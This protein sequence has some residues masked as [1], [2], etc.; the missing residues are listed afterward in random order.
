MALVTNRIAILGPFDDV[1]L[2]SAQLADDRLHACA[3]H[4]DA[5]ADRID[6]A[7]ARVHRDL[8]AIAGLAH[9]PAN[10][11]RAVV[12][13]RHFLLE[14]LDEE[15][16]IGA[17][18]DDLGPLGAAVH[19][20]DD[21]AHAIAGRVVLG[22]RLFLA[23]ELRFDPAELDDDVAVLE[24]LHHAADHFADALAVLGVDVLAL[25]LP[26]LLKDHLLGRLGGDAAQIFGRARE[27]DLHV[28]FRFFAV[29][30]LRFAERDL[31]R[32]VGDFG[33]DLLDRVQ[34]ELAGLR[35]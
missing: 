10:H 3:L 15:R 4:A 28:D 22:A 25:S 35:D 29:E 2:F 5:R 31:R 9:G 11:H 17:R 12:D 16:R 23:R 8:G 21:R 30:L 24:P 18:Q 33:D 13:F 20:A 1:D 34:L 6:V 7:L 19:A 27:L 26:D 32:R 14:E